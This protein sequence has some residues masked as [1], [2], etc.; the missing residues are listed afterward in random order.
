MEE[1]SRQ[2]IFLRCLEIT[3]INM[4][5]GLANVRLNNCHIHFKNSCSR[6]SNPSNRSTIFQT[7]K[8]CVMMAHH[9]NYFN[10]F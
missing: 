5:K 3:Y 4:V 8:N 10:N 7:F 1:E 9:R 6:N 2:R